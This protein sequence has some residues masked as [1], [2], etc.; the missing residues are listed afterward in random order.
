[1]RFILFI[2]IPLVFAGDLSSVVLQETSTGPYTVGTNIPLQAVFK[3]ALGV[4]LTSRTDSI[5]LTKS[6]GSGSLAG[7]TTVSASSG[8]ATFSSINVSDSGSYT[9]T[10]TCGTCGSASLGS[11]TVESTH[12]GKMLVSVLQPLLEGKS[13]TSYSIKLSSAPTNDVTVAISTSDSKVNLKTTSLTFTSANYNAYQSV[14]IGLPNY[15][16]S[17]TTYDIVLTHAVSSSDLDYNGSADF[18]GCL[19]ASTGVTTI[20]IYDDKTPKVTVT[21]AVVLKESTSGSITIELS[22]APTA[23]VVIGATAS[24]SVTV[25]SSSFTFTSSSWAAKTATITASAL[26]GGV[27]SSTG[28]VTFSITSSDSDYSA[29]ALRPLDL[30]STVTVVSSSSASIVLSSTSLSVQIASTGT[31]TVKLGA[32]PTSSVT[33]SLTSGDSTVTVSPTSITFTTSNWSTAVTVTATVTAPTSGRLG[34]FDVYVKHAVS[35][36]SD[37]RYSS[38]NSVSLQVNVANV[39]SPGLYTWPSAS[40]CSTVPKGFDSTLASCA[41][42]SYN[43]SPTTSCTACTAGKSCADPTASEVTCSSGYYSTATSATACIQCAAGKICTLTTSAGTA[44]SSSSY[45]LPGSSSCTSV[46]SAYNA[47]SE[48]K[49]ILKCPYGS[50][51]TDP[52]ITCAYCATG[53]YC[54][55]TAAAGTACPDNKVSVGGLFATGCQSCPSHMASTSKTTCTFCA[56]GTYISSGSC[57]NCTAGSYCSIVVPGMV[58][59]CPFGFYSSASAELCTYAAAGKYLTDATSTETSCVAGTFSTIAARDCTACRYGTTSTTGSSSCTTTT[60]GNYAATPSSTEAAC[61]TTYATRASLHCSACLPG[62]ECASS[63]VSPTAADCSSNYCIMA[64]TSGTLGI[65]TSTCQAGTFGFKTRGT[66]QVTSCAACPSGSTCNSGNAAVTCIE[67]SFCPPRSSSENTPKCPAGTYG[68]ATG[69]LEIGQCTTCPSGKFCV[70]G[71][72]SS[73]YTTCPAGYFCPIGSIAAT[74]CPR[75]TYRDSTGGSSLTDC[76][77]CP[78]GAYC[79]EASIEPTL[80]PPGTYSSSTKIG[81]K[82]NCLKCTAGSACPLS[83]LDSAVS[84]CK[85]GYYCPLGTVNPDDFPCLPGTYSTSTSLK[86]FDECTECPGGKACIEGSTAPADCAAGHYCPL[87]TQYSTEFPCPP[88]TSYSGVD[89][90]SESFCATCVAGTVCLPGTATPA[91]CQAGH[92]CPAG[93]EY[94]NQYPCPAG[95]FSSST[96][97]AASTDCTACTPGHYCPKGSTAEVDCPAGMY[98]SASNTQAR[99]PGDLTSCLYCPAGKYCASAATSTPVDC[100]PGKYSAEEATVCSNCLIG[101]VCSGGTSEATMYATKCTAGKYCPGSVSDVSSSP[102]TDCSVGNY[103]PEGT[104]EEIPCPAGRYRDTVGAAAET[105]CPLTPAGYYTNTPGA[106]SYSANLCKAGY[107]CPEGSISSMTKVCPAGTYRTSTGAGAE[108]DC[109]VC[110]A[111]SYCRYE[112]TTSLTDCPQGYYC[113]KGTTVPE[114]CPVGTYGAA[115]KLTASS[116][117]TDCTA[118]KYCDSKGITAPTGNCLAG[119]YCTLKSI[120]ATPVD[121]TTGNV[122]TRGGY[123]ETGAS[124]PVACP[125]GSYNIFTGSVDSS[126]CITCPSG[127]YCSGTSQPTPTAQCNAGYYCTGGAT[128]AQQ[129]SATAGYYTIAGSSSQIPCMQGTFSSSSN[130]ST[131]DACTAGKYCPNT[132]MSTPLD[133]PEGYYCPTGSVMPKPCP[134]GTFRASTGATAEAD[135]TLCTGGNYCL[136]TGLTAVTGTCLKGYFCTEGSVYAAPITL[137][138]GK[139]GPCPTGK[140]CAAGTTTPTDCLAGT[141]NP[142]TGGMSSADC[143]PCPAGKY[144]ATDGLDAITGDCTAGYYC[145][146]GSTST[147][148]TICPTG[149]YCPASAPNKIPCEPGTYQSST[150][151]ST[152]TTCDAGKYCTRGVDAGTSCEAGYYCPAGT[153]YAHQYPCPPGKFNSNTD[154]VDDTACQDCTGGMYCETK[155]LSA[156][157]GD[158]AAGYY[159]SGASITSKPPESS[160]YGGICRRGQF[161]PEKSTSAQACTGGYYCAQD[162]LGAETAQCTA[163]Y[164]CTTGV[165]VA[166]PFSSDKSETVGNICPTG[167]YCPEGSSAKTACVAG[168]YLPYRGASDVAECIDCPK[169]YYCETDGLA[170]Y[171]GQCTAGYYCSGGTTTP[172]AQCTAGHMC[173]LGS[174]AE[175]LCPEGTYQDTAG[176]STCTDCPTGKYCPEGSTSPQSCPVGYY[177]LSKTRHQYQYPCEPGTYNSAT[178]KTA[179]TDCLTCPVGKYCDGPANSSPQDCAAGWYCK[180]SAINDRPITTDNGGICEIGSYCA[181]GSSSMTGCTSGKY[182]AEDELSAPTGDC[183]N[184]FRCISK[185]YTSMPTDGTTGQIC[186]K[187]KYC[188]SGST[189]ET[190]CSIGTYN[191]GKGSYQASDCLD[192][193]YG[194]YCNSLALV[195]PSSLCDAGYYCSTGNTQADP[196]G[197]VCSAGYYCPQGSFE[198]IPC[199]IG[200][201]NTLTQQSTCSTCTAG[202]YCAGGT[203]GEASCGA[204]YYCPSGTRFDIEFPCEAGSY[205]STT[206]KSTCDSCPAGNECGPGSS[207]TGTTCPLY[208]YCPSGTAYA[209]L[210]EA[211]KYNDDTTGLTSNAS[212][213]DCPAGNYCVDGRVSGLCSAGYFCSGGSPTPTPS[214]SSYGKP[215]PIGYYCLEGTTTPTSCPD[216]KFRKLTGGRLASDCTE[217]PPGYYCVTGNPEPILC[218]KGYYCPQGVKEP[219][220]CPIRTYSSSEGASSDETCTVCPGGYICNV[221]ATSDYTKYPCK[222]GYFCVKGGQ[223]AIPCPPGTFTSITTAATISDCQTCSGG[224]Q[225]PGASDIEKGCPVGTYCP[226]AS[227]SPKPCPMGYYCNGNTTLPVICEEKKYCP[228]YKDSDKI[229]T[230]SNSTTGTV[231]ASYSFCPTETETYCP[232]TNSTSSYN[233]SLPPFDCPSNAYCPK[234]SFEPQ[235]CGA[236]YYI[237]YNSCKLCTKGSYSLGAVKSCTKCDAGYLCI[238]GAKKAT[239]TDL[240]YFGGYMCPVGYYCEAGALAA[241]PCPAGTYNQFEGASSKDSCI[242]CAKDTYSS[243]EG[244][245][246]C[247]PCGPFASAPT[248]ST[249]CSCDGDERAYQ[250]SDASCRCRPRY[251]F[252]QESIVSSEDDSDTDCYPKIFPR[253]SKDEYRAPD[254]SCKSENDCSSECGG[255]GGTRMEGIGLCKCDK[256]KHID[257]VCNKACRDTSPRVYVG[258]NGD[259]LVNDPS[260]NKNQTVKLTG[261]DNYYGSL[262]CT[263]SNC[264]MYNVD[265]TSSGPIAKYGLGTALS[266]YYNST[267]SKRRYLQTTNSTASTDEIVN[268]VACIYQGE[269]FIFSIPDREHYPIYDKD[270]LIN[271]NDDFDYG[272]FKELERM[273]DS[274]S[275]NITTFAFTF[276]EAGI[277]DFVDNAD[278]DLHFIISVIG[279]GEQC[280]DPDIPLRTRTESSLLTVGAKTSDDIILEPD[281]PLI[282]GL[283]GGFV[284]LTALIIGGLYFFHMKAWHGLIDKTA[285]YREANLKHEMKDLMNGMAAIL[286]EPG[287]EQDEILKPHQAVGLIAELQTTDDLDPA[288]FQAMHQR[289]LEHKRLLETGFSSTGDTQTL[290]DSLRKTRALRAQID[291]CLALLQQKEG[292]NREEESESE[293]SD[294]EPEI[295]RNSMRRISTVNRVVI[296]IQKENQV[297]LYQSITDDP[298]LSERDKEALLADYNR[299]LANIENSLNSD[300]ART[301]DSLEARLKE[302]ADRRKKRQAA[303]KKERDGPPLTITPMFSPAAI[304]EAHEQDEIEEEA[305]EAQDAQEDKAVTADIQDK[306]RV[307]KDQLDKNLSNAHTEEERQALI[308]KYNLEVSKLEEMLASHKQ[309]QEDQLQQRLAERR[310]RR[311][312]KDK[313]L[314]DLDAMPVAHE[315]PATERK[316]VSFNAAGLSTLKRLVTETIAKLDYNRALVDQE[317]AHDREVKALK[318]EFEREKKAIEADPALHIDLDQAK[319]DMLASL[320]RNAAT[321]AGARNLQDDQLQERLRQKRQRQAELKRRQQ[322]ALRS[323]EDR[324][325]HEREALVSDLT[326]QSASDLLEQNRNL[327]EKDRASLL[328]NLLEEKQER[329]LAELDGRKKSRLRDQ[330]NEVLSDALRYKAEQLSNIRRTHQQRLKIAE[331]TLTEPELSRELD[332]QKSALVEAEAQID[333]DFT[334][335][336]SQAQNQSARTIESD[337]RQRFLDLTNRHMREAAELLSRLGSEGRRE[338]EA[339][340][341]DN[342]RLVEAAE[343]QFDLFKEEMKAKEQELLRLNAEKESELNEL[344]AAIAAAEARKKELAEIEKQRKGLLEKQRLMLEESRR[345]GISPEQIEEMLQEHAKALSEWENSVDIERRR[346]QDKLNAKLSLRVKN[347]HLKRLSTIPQQLPIIQEEELEIVRPID[348]AQILYEPMRDIESRLRIGVMPTYERTN[349]KVDSGDSDLLTTLLAKVKRVERIVANVDAVRFS[350]LMNDCNRL[351]ERIQKLSKS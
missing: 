59:T 184:G 222:K 186:S 5:T 92:Y 55:S 10:I 312:Q 274:N 40:S 121:G 83:G 334:N 170:T 91:S 54:S 15:T 221:K 41:V 12:T 165:K 156:P 317:K 119:F 308:D 301:Q 323:L 51:T 29:A 63:S 84:S 18:L 8:V 187:G 260:T 326:K 17:S 105:D 231:C 307:L 209:L 58:V 314:L 202:N 130:L 216:G 157:T 206:G 217:C 126:S 337:F 213:K 243:K 256:T 115:T 164:F 57:T 240:D 111:G 279:D 267:S 281:W 2:L 194:M 38:L 149:H 249:T 43:S 80:C 128:T 107:Y 23:N 31:Y 269:A 95:T 238:L 118:G 272:T 151:Q 304:P 245:S 103:C 13:S 82:K 349:I 168:K 190:D 140:Y 86:S 133:C 330:Q 300:K 60:A 67:G 153:S 159:C 64:V 139:Y 282:C 75:G 321:Q 233:A 53:T 155:G 236:G 195:T 271:T 227:S 16:T 215:C 248:N 146:R 138:A 338:S 101:Y 117:C 171:T 315:A 76:A 252:S 108:S 65:A 173:P 1:M 73:T 261:F 278:N 7:T 313:S 316:S 143:L 309:R 163:G 160:S 123:C 232:A 22:V 335:Y 45:S 319:R 183:T 207:T 290:E 66:N 132:Q 220:P 239:P 62:Y 137:S 188:A 208:K 203:S 131:C 311:A 180:G 258:S 305:L 182:C 104:T 303:L 339:F 214:E 329:E 79:P 225:C 284:M 192:C 193:P 3:D 285:K 302:R 50:Y 244:Q 275:T 69:L 350:S 20:P 336:L 37:S 78:T 129:N 96:S 351:V 331:Q 152:C 289:L 52:T 306:M 89:A 97:L 56:Q 325:D 253:C 28:T 264:R 332:R 71:D 174:H 162:L 124:A 205:T 169:G 74:P 177:C 229:Y 277:F 199:E 185:A 327:S 32:L 72:T 292:L 48:L 234:G 148:A 343:A 87:G 33:V 348:R 4:T 120:T 136:T 81:N 113:M 181:A 197:S 266:P 219:S 283:L 61:T 346:Q 288:I 154:S 158:C 298:N 328:R 226:A 259:L 211:G 212:C 318:E 109:L 242:P 230:F 191:S 47:S 145:E 223:T 27:T 235:Y 93:T 112:A 161:C 265:M 257:E 345:K 310:R 88:G 333:F 125:D 11:V 68:T 224:K 254:G 19:T 9:F 24:G 294:S 251:H 49:V 85:A 94:A 204:G 198:Q 142:N 237:E 342:A 262:D 114:P 189:S 122:C 77:D 218:P 324:Q 255:G 340:S 100:D 46:T 90:T 34:G 276:T 35:S 6:S 347:A 250:E 98:A 241:I 178:D 144:C 99:L 273:L 297:D 228:K 42:G 141:Y 106:S 299:Q 322:D 200:E 135:C 263:S 268:P 341:A 270:S 150:G 26:S 39:C 201:Y 176:Q 246:A 102:A 70:S 21:E 287:Q 172:T 344:N 296:D 25:G 147:T 280:P 295:K 175:V 127:F 30:V 134:A 286:G 320:D 116:D 167:H 247:L 44:C 293:S 179:K 14:S 110:D 291:A 196:P 36:S 166:S 210:C